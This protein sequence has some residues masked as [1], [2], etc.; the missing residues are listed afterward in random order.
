MVADQM[1]RSGLE[2]GLGKRSTTKPTAHQQ[3]VISLYETFQTQQRLAE[4]NSCV[5]IG[6][7]LAINHKVHKVME[8]DIRLQE[9]EI[10][11]E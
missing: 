9:Y 6:L 8:N 7:L 11:V 5:R 3:K 4:L 2:A 10:L 1:R